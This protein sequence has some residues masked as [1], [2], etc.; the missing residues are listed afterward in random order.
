MSELVMVEPVP[1]MRTRL[2]VEPAPV[3]GHQGVAGAAV[4]HVVVAAVGEQVV[5]HQRLVGV[6]VGV[7]DAR[8]RAQRHGPCQ[9]QA[10]YPSRHELLGRHDGSLLQKSCAGLRRTRPTR[11]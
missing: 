3:G 1:V 7:A 9:Q 10:R 5:Q 2:P 11:Y 4:A 6:P 8:C